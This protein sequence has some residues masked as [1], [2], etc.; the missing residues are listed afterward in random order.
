MAKLAADAVRARE[1]A[2]VY[3]DAAADAR[4]QRDEDGGPA[5]GAAAHP[6]FAEGGT[7]RVVPGAHAQA[8]QNAEGIM[9][10]EYAPVQVHAAVDHAG[11]IHRARHADAEAEAVVP[12]KSAAD[13][14][15][16]HATRDVRQDVLA[17]V[18]R[19]RGKLPLFQKLAR[20]A[21]QTE[22]DRRSADVDTESVFHKLP[23][24]LCVFAGIMSCVVGEGTARPGAALV[25]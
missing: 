2:A 16:L 24:L 9:Q 5:A 19:A 7:V 13:H 6:E 25:Q 17:A 12:R 23:H 11:G 22:L 8:R 10:V 20:L 4:S 1:Q 3:D 15:V 18:F 14:A 21:E